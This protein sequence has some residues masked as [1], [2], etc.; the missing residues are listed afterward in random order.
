MNDNSELDRLVDE[1]LRSYVANEPPVGLEQR[2]LAKVRLHS[3]KSVPARWWA[4]GL[5]AAIC[6]LV[7]CFVYYH[8]ATPTRVPQIAGMP[9]G[10]TPVLRN[11]VSRPPRMETHA[12]RSPRVHAAARQIGKKKVFPLPEPLTQ[13]ERLLLAY[14]ATDAH[15]KTQPSLAANEPI[16]VE[17]IRIAEIHIDS[18]PQ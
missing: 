9:S 6:L 2:V 15:T 13:Q 3:P 1:A 4:L 12:P 14:A 10:T 11:D 8:A 18:L 16:Q 7:C 5:A 17:P